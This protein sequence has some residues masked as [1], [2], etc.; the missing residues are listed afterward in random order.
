MEDYY[1]YHHRVV[2]R[3]RR[4]RA[5]VAVLAVLALLCAGV[6]GYYFAVGQGALPDLLTA[7]PVNT[8]LSQ[9]AEPAASQPASVPADTPTDTPQPAPEAPAA[10]YMPRRL[11]PEADAAVWNTLTPVPAPDGLDQGY[12]NTD[13]RMVGVPANGTVDDSFFDTVTFVG[14]SIASGLG[15]YESGLPHAHFAAY[16]SAAASSFVN[17]VAMTN[18]VTKVKETPLETILASQPDCLY[19]HVG[20]NDLVNPAETAVQSYIN[21]YEHLIGML[22]EMLPGVAIYVQSIPG[23]Q[24]DVVSSKPG[25]DNTRIL[26]VNNMVANMALRTGCYFV[27]TQ[28]ALA[29][30]DGSAIDG[31][32]AGDGIHFNPG[33]YRAWADYLRTHTVWSRRSVYIGRNPYYIYGR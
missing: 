31:Y 20:T 21:Y 13:F 24:E 22:R 16:T 23:T 11:L 15:I 2:A 32:S 26:T 27:N 4:R 19:L 18:A 5:V 9:P 14:D 17:D 30:A 6:G 25:L 7:Q 8:A 1:A 3:K 28:E 29:N 12:Y 10:A 33:G